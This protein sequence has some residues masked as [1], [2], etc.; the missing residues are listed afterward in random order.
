[1]AVVMRRLFSAT[2]CFFPNRNRDLFVALGVRLWHSQRQHRDLGGRNRRRL[3][4]GKKD[5][6]GGRESGSD[7][8]KGYMRRQTVTISWSRELPL[9]QGIRFDLST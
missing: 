8:W 4:G 9:A 5:T 7:A 6:G 3:F 2:P 1:V